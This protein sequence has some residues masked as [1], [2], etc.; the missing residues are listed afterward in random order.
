MYIDGFIRALE[1]V[2]ETDKIEAV[3]SEL[4]RNANKLDR[5][6]FQNLRV[7]E[8]VFGGS[9]AGGRL[10]GHHGRAHQVI[11]ETIDGVI[12]DMRDF[13]EGVVKAETMIK[14]ADAGAEAD[15]S[16]KQAAVAELEGANKWFEGDQKYHEARNDQGADRR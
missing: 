7:S 16:K 4:L 6:H 1:T 5:G 10:G 8:S 14:D 12:A 3:K 11:A 2:V 15:L 9:P 13:R